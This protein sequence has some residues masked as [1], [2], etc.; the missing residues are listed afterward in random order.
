MPDLLPT[1]AHTLDSDNTTFPVGKE[2]ALLS[3]MVGLLFGSAWV[4]AYLA[5]TATPEEEN[6]LAALSLAKEEESSDL[7]P[8]PYI[9]EFSE[10]SLQAEAAYVYDAASEVAL[11]EKN[12]DTALPLASVTKLMTA[13]LASEILEGNEI[14]TISE[15]AVAAEGDSGLRA[16]EQFTVSDL[17]DMTLTS[18]SNDGA[19]ALA[20]TAGNRLEPGGGVAFFIAAMNIRA[21]ELGMRQ[22]DFKNPTGLDL[23]LVED[24]GVGSAKDITLLLQH[25]IGHSPSLLESTRVP[26]DRI[27]NLQG[28]YHNLSNTNYTTSQISGLLGSKTGYTDLAGGNLAIVYDSGLAHPVIVVVLGSTRNERFSDVLALVQASNNFIEYTQ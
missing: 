13:L 25:I 4:P 19:M 14:I 20:E 22:A 6:S 10:L 1:E 24:G 26:R 5:K 23:N 3:I 28:D 11:F 9:D 15:R 18:S 12:A 8:V 7:A 21:A 27:Y 2:L 17:I 16:G